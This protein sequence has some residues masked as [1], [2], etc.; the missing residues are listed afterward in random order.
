MSRITPAEID[1][2][3]QQFEEFRSSDRNGP[4][5]INGFLSGIDEGTRSDPGLV[6]ELVQIDIQLNWMT[7]DKNIVELVGHTDLNVIRSRFN[8]IPR[9][10]DYVM[11]RMGQAG[12]AE[13]CAFQSAA[14]CEMEARNSW[15]DAIGLFYYN[16]KYGLE[17]APDRHH[18]PNRLICSIDGSSLGRDSPN[19]SLRGRT[20]I[21]RQRQRDPQELFLEQLTEGNRI[22]IASKL[23]NR[24]SREQLVVELLNCQYAIVTNLSSQNAVV[25]ANTGT[26]EPTRSAVL[27]F[28]FSI[29][30]PGRRLNLST[31]KN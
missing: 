29:R 4:Q 31:S 24:I 13:F 28:D 22:I 5:A 20:V 21:G 3:S 19:F 2:L 18:R 15:G 16:S 9:L 8:S 11:L 14:Q 7:W 10:D 30:L 23:D 12:S 17:L 1:E 27:P 26:L 25:I 6:T